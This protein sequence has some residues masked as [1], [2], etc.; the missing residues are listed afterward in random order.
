MLLGPG[1]A[2]I[3]A[4]DAST[5]RS[6]AGGI[7]ASVGLS[8][9][10]NGGAGAF[11]AAFS[12]NQIGGAGEGSSVLA[13]VDDSEITADGDIQ[14]D[15]VSASQIFALA[16]GAAGSV[17]GSGSGNAIAGSLA[18][19]ASVNKI[20]VRNQRG[21]NGSKLTTRDGMG[22]GIRVTADDRSE[23]DAVAGS[24]SLSIAVGQSTSV[25]AGLGLSLTINDIENTTRAAVE[26]SEVTSGST[27]TVTG[28]QVN[29]STYAAG[30][31]ATIT[32]VGTITIGSTGAYTFTPVAGFTGE[33]PVITYSLTGGETST[34]TLTV[35]GASDTFTDGSE[36]VQ[37]HRRHERR[38]D[39]RGQRA[40]KRRQGRRQGRGD[41]LPGGRRRHGVRR[42]RH[43]RDP[44]Q[45]HRRDRRGRSLC[46]HSEGGLPR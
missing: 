24:A 27:G 15:A 31:T 28:F 23:I 13:E 41:E 45:G 25:A 35:D 21:A 19:S 7:A 8:S 18:G 38:N 30:E 36:S 3:S 29:G 14:I 2:T 43:R 5:I 40:P 17:T 33:V 4:E 20:R 44:R 42:R 46:F 22:G 1:S 9:S 12:V 26:D 11:G 37:R 34:L 16:V 6:G 39:R 10:G 32:G